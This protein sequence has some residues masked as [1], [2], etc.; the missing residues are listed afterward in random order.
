MK[1]QLILFLLLFP[2]IITYANK[3]DSLKTYKDVE[4]FIFSQLVNKNALPIFKIKDLYRTDIQRRTAKKLGVKPWQKAD[5][6]LDGRTDLLVHFKFRGESGNRLVVF[7][8]Q[9][10]FF[11]PINLGDFW[12][13][14]NLYY[15]IVYFDDK[16]PLIKLY[17]GCYYCDEN[18]KIIYDTATLIYKFGNFIEYVKDIPSC[19]IEK[20]SITTTSLCDGDCNDFVFSIDSNRVAKY[21][22]L[23][24]NNVDIPDFGDEYVSEVDSAKYAELIEIINGIDIINLHESYFSGS[25]ES[26]EYTLNITYNSGLTKRIEDHGTLGTYGL[27]MIYRLLFKIKSTQKWVIR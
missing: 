2:A 25:I 24:Y 16:Q 20:I 19:K 10:S 9:G 15:P 8:D 21:F 5:F 11:S 12:F 17:K 26:S 4:T 7:I 3:V 14:D 1:K 22:D 23:I 18:M 27:R 6:N 13:M